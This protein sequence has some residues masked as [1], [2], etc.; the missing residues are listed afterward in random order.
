MPFQLTTLPNVWG[1]MANDS[2][3]HRLHDLVGPR[4][5]ASLKT[6]ATGYSRMLAQR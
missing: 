5:L 3:P 4:D 1:L 6:F 2:R